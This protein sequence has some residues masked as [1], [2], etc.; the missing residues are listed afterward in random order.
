MRRADFDGVGGVIT[1]HVVPTTELTVSADLA[2]VRAL[3]LKLEASPGNRFK[4][5]ASA[6]QPFVLQLLL[7]FAEASADLSLLPAAPQ[8]DC[9]VR[10]T[11]VGLLDDDNSPLALHADWFQSDVNT[12]I[13]FVGGAWMFRLSGQSVPITTALSFD[14]ISITLVYLN[15]RDEE[16]EEDGGTGRRRS[17]QQLLATNASS[18]SIN[19]PQQGR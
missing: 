9:F 14:A 18:V 15:G 13:A 3:T 5:T 4:I 12:K 19:F 11:L 2:S 7:D 8:S 17:V 16:E 6:S 10:V 1:R